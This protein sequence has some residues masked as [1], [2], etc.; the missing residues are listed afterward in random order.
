MTPEEEK[1]TKAILISAGMMLIM[2]VF[3]IVAIVLL[4]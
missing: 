1:E 3:M 4:P 2:L